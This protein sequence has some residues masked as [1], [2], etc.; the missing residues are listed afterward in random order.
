MWQKKKPRLKPAPKQREIAAELAGEPA[1]RWCRQNVKHWVTELR[2]IHPNYTRKEVYDA[3]ISTNPQA[4]HYRQ[5]YIPFEEEGLAKNGVGFQHQIA[6]LAIERENDIAQVQS[7]IVR[8]GEK[9]R[10]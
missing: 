5:K 7:K 4:H 3:Y 8:F 1:L 6:R 9:P 10:C 2:K